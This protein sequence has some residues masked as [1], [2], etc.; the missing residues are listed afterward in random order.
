MGFITVWMMVFGYGILGVNCVLQFSAWTSDAILRNTGFY[1]GW[2]Y[3]GI[4]LI[5]VSVLLAWR[6]INQSLNLCLV[7]GSVEF[8]IVLIFSIILAVKVI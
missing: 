1:L 8:I 6:G 4:T 3:I 7:L 2:Y 5:L